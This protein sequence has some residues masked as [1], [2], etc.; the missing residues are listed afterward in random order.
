M[1]TSAYLYSFISYISI[2]IFLFL[3]PGNLEIWLDKLLIF[4]TL[5][6][7]AARVVKN[8]RPPHKMDCWLYLNIWYLGHGFYSIGL[9]LLV[10]QK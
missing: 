4:P 3:V 5:P 10:N 2:G 7:G 1:C 8:G 6:C 9:K